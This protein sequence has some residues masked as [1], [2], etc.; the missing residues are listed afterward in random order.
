MI[1]KI[2]TVPNSKMGARIGVLNDADVQALDQAMF[3]FLGLA[4]ASRRG[5][6]K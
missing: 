3:V 5:R 2:V 6:S 4:A 1:D